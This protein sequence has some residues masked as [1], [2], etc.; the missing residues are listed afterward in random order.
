MSAQAAQLLVPSFFGAKSVV[1]HFVQTVAGLQTAQAAPHPGEPVG[2]VPNT[3]ATVVPPTAAV[4]CATVAPAVTWAAVPPTVTWAVVPPAVTWAAVAPAVTWAVV[5]P[6]V[7]WAAV[8]PAV[9]VATVPPATVAAPVT[10]VPFAMQVPS[11]D[12]DGTSVILLHS[13]QAVTV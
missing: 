8:P 6:A 5:P 2:T 4:T 1:I 11:P 12:V 10:L 3:G 7:T 9:T 13:V